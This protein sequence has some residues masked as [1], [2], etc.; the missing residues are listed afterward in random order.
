MLFR[1]HKVSFI[2]PLPLAMYRELAAHLRQINLV[3]TQLCPQD[4]PLFD[5]ADSQIGAIAIKFPEQSYGSVQN[6]LSHYGT[7]HILE[8]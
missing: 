6:I 2:P 5:Y 8:S 4:A 3:E 1:Q 7:W